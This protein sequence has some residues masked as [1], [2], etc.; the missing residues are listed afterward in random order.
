MTSFDSFSC[1]WS[2]T[3]CFLVALY[4]CVQLSKIVQKH[5][6][7][8]FIYNCSHF[9]YSFCNQLVLFAQLKNVKRLWNN[10]RT[11]HM[12]ERFKN[13]NKIKSRDIQIDDLAHKNYN[14]II[15]G[16]RHWLT[17]ES[18]GRFLVNNLLILYINSNI[19]ILF[20]LNF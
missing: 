14:G 1:C 4:S 8:S 2:L 13:K 10:N 16:W 19:T 9:Q 7:M 5:H 17:S 12:N 6:E 11:M 20:K 15:K 3:I 18:K